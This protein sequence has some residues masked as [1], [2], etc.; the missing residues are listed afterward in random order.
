T[1]RR[2][3][4]TRESSGSASTPTSAASHTK[5][6]DPAV[7][8]R[9][10]TVAMS[11]AISRKVAFATN[12]RRVVAS[13]N[14]G[15]VVISLSPAHSSFANAFAQLIDLGVAELRVGHAQHGG[16]GLFSGS[17]EKR[18]N[19]VFERIIART[20]GVHDRQVD[21]PR[22]IFAVRDQILFHQD[23]QNRTN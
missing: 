17:V 7:A 21:V 23:P 11:A 1:P 4:S 9:S 2:N 19:H 5:W 22:S 18:T 13:A 8:R 15:L 16:N 3:E 20:L 14:G 12:S 6:R 10:G